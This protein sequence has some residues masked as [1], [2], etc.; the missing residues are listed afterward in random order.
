[1]CFTFQKSK[2]LSCLLFSIVFPVSVICDSSIDKAENN[3]N[4]T[5]S[6]VLRDLKADL[7]KSNHPSNITDLLTP[8][9]IHK[10][11]AERNKQLNFS[12]PTFDEVPTQIKSTSNMENSEIKSM[13][14]KSEE[15]D[16]KS[17]RT[18]MEKRARRKEMRK[19]CMSLS[20]QFSESGVKTQRR[21]WLV[22]SNF[23]VYQ[24]QWRSKVQN[25]SALE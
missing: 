13:T 14:N 20:K 16:N 9:N 19:K 25:C 3:F 17:G 5:L 8:S 6:V 23:N 15:S 2:F 10:L 21:I 7:I 1:M 18:K 22:L 11:F 24:L 12:K 4:S